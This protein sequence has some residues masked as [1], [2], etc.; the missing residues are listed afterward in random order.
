MNRDLRIYLLAIGLPAAVLAFWGI[1]LLFRE[2]E[3]AQEAELASLQ[4]RAEYAASDI[5]SQIRSVGDAQ[6][7]KVAS[8]AANTREREEMLRWM[9]ETDPYVRNAFIW[10]AGKGIVWPRLGNCTEEQRR[11]LERKGAQLGPDAKWVDDRP[12][13]ITGWM[14]SKG[15]LGPEV[16]SWIQVGTNVVCGMEIEVLTPLLHVQPALVANGTDNPNNLSGR[17]TIA[18]IRDGNDEIVI[19]ASSPP[20]PGTI[21]GEAP[22]DAILPGLRIRV[23]WRNGS[24]VMAGASW[25]L[26]ASGSCLL[27]LLTTSL[28][29]GGLLLLRAANRAR[30]EAL[31][32]TDFVSNVSHEFKTPLT[33]I[34]VCAELLAEDLIPDPQKRREAGRTI[35]EE[36]RRLTQ[37]VTDI[38]DFSRLERNRFS[39]SPCN[40]VLM[41]IVREL[42]PAADVPPETVVYADPSALRHV[43]RNLLE[44][45]AKYAAEGGPAEVAAAE[46]EDGRVAL[47]VSDRGPG[48]P[49][50]VMEKMFDRFWRG[51]DSVTT[52]VGGSGLG[53]SIARQFARGMG[54]DLT[55]AARDG[56]GLVFTVWLKK[57]NANG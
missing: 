18:E 33:S 30:A 3:R 43:L 25:A 24:E 49:P 55:V 38:L 48:V 2:A 31:V 10:R 37:M 14:V 52:E 47:T 45:A 50:A 46:R 27:A 15:E 39:F 4:A 29:A 7:A 11:F 28:M 34:G 1:R 5:C 23:M 12:E 26:V 54:G 17:A 21:Y 9:M 32:K 57:G 41:P 42:A 53:L 8:L 51:D 22:L 13:S 20:H 56:G 35:Y 36:A 6:L 40:F 44:N 16:I 19:P